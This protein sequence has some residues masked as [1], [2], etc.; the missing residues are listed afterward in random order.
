VGA[1][2]GRL[3]ANPVHDLFSTRVCPEEGKGKKRKDK[4]GGDSFHRTSSGW[5]R[6]GREFQKKGIR[7]EKIPFLL[8]CFAPGC[9]EVHTPR[10]EK[11]ESC[12]TLKFKFSIFAKGREFPV[13]QG[14]GEDLPPPRAVFNLG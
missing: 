5:K 6:S 3:G 7:G 10:E 11:Q 2:G 9:F 1:F 13:N 4:K 12:A 14:E 8:P